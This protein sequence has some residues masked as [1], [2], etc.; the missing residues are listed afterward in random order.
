M[1]SAVS[2]Q[3]SGPAGSIACEEN[4]SS[5]NPLSTAVSAILSI[6]SRPSHQLVW[7]W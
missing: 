7:V 1:R 2:G 3:S 5:E 6:E 4:P